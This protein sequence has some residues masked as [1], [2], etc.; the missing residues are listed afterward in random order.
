[1]KSRIIYPFLA[2]G[3]ISIAAIGFWKQYLESNRPPGGSEIGTVVKVADG[4][5]LT[6]EANGT[7]EKIRLCGVDAPE[8]QQP[9][10]MA[11]KQLLERMTLGKQVAFTPVEKDR[12]GRTVAE[13][14][15]LGNPEQFVN[16]DLVEAGLA[17]HYA[18]YSG[19]CP[20]RIVIA[21]AETIAKSK[22]VGVWAEA[23]A[24]KPWDY[25]KTTKS[26]QS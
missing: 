19:N 22:H 20:N 17:Y 6:I 10:G 9:L 2:I 13:V 26:S 8:K 21:D 23:R 11:S 15:V 18:Q 1:M 7:Q 5:T 16:S 24:V 3:I 14:Y 25:R 12:Y 4:D